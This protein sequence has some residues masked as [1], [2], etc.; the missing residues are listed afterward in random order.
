VRRIAPQ[1]RS[2]LAQR[3]GASAPLLHLIGAHGDTQ[4]ALATVVG[5]LTATIARRIAAC[6]GNAQRNERG[7]QQKHAKRTLQRAA[8]RIS[9]CANTPVPTAACECVTLC[10][11][12]DADV[13]RW[14][15]RS[16]ANKKK[17]K[18]R[19]GESKHKQSDSSSASCEPAAA[20]R[21]RQ[22]DSTECA[23]WRE[24]G[25]MSAR[26]SECAHENTQWWARAKV[27]RILFFCCGAQHLTA[28]RPADAAHST[29]RERTGS[30]RARAVQHVASIFSFFSLSPVRFFFLF[31]VATGSQAS[32]LPTS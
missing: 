22:C 25:A 14:R 3:L 5:Q 24:R 31:L 9:R 21:F 12:A 10:R 29:A 32:S 18:K 26:R 8:A 19:A 23:T 16:V 11:N 2:A 20:Q 17:K 7:A 13:Q 4:N 30:V 1:T 15:E 28:A 27:E 6:A